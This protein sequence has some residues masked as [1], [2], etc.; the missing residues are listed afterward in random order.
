M[1][2]QHLYESKANFEPVFQTEYFKK[3][4]KPVIDNISEEFMRE[5]QEMDKA[6]R[7]KYF[8]SELGNEVFLLHGSSS[9]KYNAGDTA[10]IVN[11]KYPTDSNHIIHDMVNELSRERFDTE[12]RN[13]IF[14]SK[15]IAIASEYGHTYGNIYIAVPTGSYDLYYSTTYED[16]YVDFL[17]QNDIVRIELQDHED[18]F[19]AILTIRKSKEVKE[20]LKKYITIDNKNDKEDVVQDVMDTI[21]NYA[22]KE[23]KSYVLDHMYR[24]NILSEMDERIV[25]YAERVGSF[26]MFLLKGK[27]V[28]LPTRLE[29]EM[30]HIVWEIAEETVGHFLKR[31]KHHANMYI[32]T[33]HKTSDPRKI[34]G[35]TE[36]MLDTASVIMIPIID[37]YEFIMESKQ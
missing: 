4:I 33:V 3:N 19:K 24:T 11:R 5:L 23:F 20:L 30:R 13:K 32:D 7:F 26:L 1:K 15:S 2:I 12:I 8:T 18:T 28:S 10:E 14:V 9:K 34:E 25:K 6:R 31:L 22:I 29:E 36:I 27:N 16:F 17:N 37:F 35:Q 21:N